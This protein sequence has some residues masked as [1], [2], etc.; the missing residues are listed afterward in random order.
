M[1]LIPEVPLK[2]ILGHSNAFRH[3]SHSVDQVERLIIQNEA[4]LN[5]D[6][7]ID[8]LRFL[9]YVGMATMVAIVLLICCCFCKRCNFL[10]RSLGDDCC[11]RIC[12][13]Q[14][15]INQREDKAS[16]E[17]V[18]DSLTRR[19]AATVCDRS[20]LLRVLR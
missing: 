18:T 13:R 20:K 8:H 6:H 3:A 15:V 11:G 14:T 4:E 2:N 12:I 1:K 19:L 16:D 7:K 5:R 10:R 17:N 9:S